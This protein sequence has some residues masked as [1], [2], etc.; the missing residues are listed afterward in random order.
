[1]SGFQQT[2][3]KHT[4]N[5]ALKDTVNVRSRLECNRDITIIGLGI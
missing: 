2:I 4:E 1:M 5:M 3:M